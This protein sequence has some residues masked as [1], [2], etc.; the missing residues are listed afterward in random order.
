M[1]NNS[2]YQGLVTDLRYIGGASSSAKY[3]SPTSVTVP[4]GSFEA[5]SAIGLTEESTLRSGE[6]AGGETERIADAAPGST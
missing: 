6:T 5:R 1:N 2:L 3:A 4:S